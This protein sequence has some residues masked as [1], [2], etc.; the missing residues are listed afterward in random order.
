[1]ARR[2]RPRRKR[3][4]RLEIR[5]HDSLNMSGVVFAQCKGGGQGM[6]GRCKKQGSYY[7]LNEAVPE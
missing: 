3:V 5:R 1:M 2:R 7:L 4:V 6:I